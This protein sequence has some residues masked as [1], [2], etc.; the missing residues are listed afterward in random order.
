MATAKK[1]TTKAEPL[2]ALL[3]HI[4]LS[5]TLNER[6]VVRSFIIYQYVLAILVIHTFKDK[7]LLLFCLSPEPWKV[8]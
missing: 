3:F 5:I 1:K 4:Q 6:R 7:N 8:D 2:K